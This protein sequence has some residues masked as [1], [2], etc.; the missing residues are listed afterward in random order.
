MEAQMWSIVKSLPGLLF[1]I[2]ACLG[3][4][5]NGCDQFASDVKDCLEK[6]RVK[7]MPP[8]FYSSILNPTLGKDAFDCFLENAAVAYLPKMCTDDGA[9]TIMMVCGK[10]V[11]FKNAPREYKLAALRYAD[12][13]VECISTGRKKYVPLGRGL[14]ENDTYTNTDDDYG[15]TDEFAMLEEEF[16]NDA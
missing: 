1:V 16:S 3:Q 5:D 14:V 4:K 10:D 7:D 11:V 9:L 15:I 13:F 6:T 12:K 8:E 2:Q